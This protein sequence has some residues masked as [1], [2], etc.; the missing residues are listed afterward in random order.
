M[1]ACLNRMTSGAGLALEDFV[2][3]SADAG[4]AGRMWI[5]IMPCSMAPAL[6]DLYAK[7]NQRFGGWGPPIAPQMPP[8]RR[9]ELP[10]CGRFQSRPS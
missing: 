8:K 10:N 5:S 3:L 9:T 1:Y 2:K 6:R 7:H 4:F